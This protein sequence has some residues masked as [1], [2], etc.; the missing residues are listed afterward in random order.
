[1]SRMPSKLYS[2]SSLVTGERAV[3]LQQVKLE[4]SEAEMEQELKET[5]TLSFMIETR[6]PLRLQP[7]G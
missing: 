7:L 6:D 1:M 4:M 3:E 2:N 5:E